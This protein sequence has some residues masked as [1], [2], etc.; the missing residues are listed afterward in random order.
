MA[1]VRQAAPRLLQRVQQCHSKFE[2]IYAPHPTWPLPHP[3]F[4]QP[5]NTPRP[6]RISVLDS[7]FNPPTLAHLAL[8]NSRR[9]QSLTTDG[10]AP[11]ATQLFYDA[12]LLLLS[13]KNADKTLKPG[14]ATYQ[15]RLEMMDLLASDVQA[16][17][18]QS[19]SLSTSTS[20]A[21]SPVER[22]NVAIAIIDEPTFVGKS[23]TL[24]TFLRRRL[25]T[26]NPPLKTLGD[27]ELTFIVGL[28]TLERL[29]SPR[30]Y[31]SETAMMT[32]LRKFFSPGPDG[33]NSR[34]ISAQ[35]IMRPPFS[36]QA[37]ESDP[38][39][40][41]KEFIDSG[42][43][44]II[45]LGDQISTYSSTTVRRSRNSVGSGQDSLWR[46]LVTKPVAEYIVEQHLYQDGL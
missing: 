35:R 19:A 7:S 44:A 3:K 32:S 13:V 28:D 33:D 22:A 20:D 38:L 27:I 34:I 12:K 26:L 25:S 31:P 16:D 29:F 45:D 24:L 15:Q 46:K 42:R 11:K 9:S 37:Q 4:V 6:L 43:I 23:A 21:L 41:A 14:D 18:D 36:S 17:A 2:L 10:H 30:Y 5:D 8:A 40:L 39:S 1:T